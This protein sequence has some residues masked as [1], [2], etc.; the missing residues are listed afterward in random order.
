MCEVAY[1]KVDYNS[2]IK[3]SFY[4]KKKSPNL[5]TL[6]YLLSLNTIVRVGDVSPTMV[7]KFHLSLVI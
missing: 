5:N 2:R 6:P 3:R 1:S 7:S 4:D